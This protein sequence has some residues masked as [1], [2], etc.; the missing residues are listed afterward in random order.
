MGTLDKWG[1]KVNE[2]SLETLVPKK[3]LISTIADSLSIEYNEN[4]KTVSIYLEDLV[5]IS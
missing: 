5:P 3:D 2:E 4:T 1:K